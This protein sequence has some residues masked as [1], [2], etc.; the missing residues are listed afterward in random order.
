V[1][2]V[3]PRIERVPREVEVVVVEALREILGGRADLDEVGAPGPAQR[4]RWL[5]EEHV[6]VDRLIRPAGRAV[7]ARDEPYDRRIAFGECALLRAAGGRGRCNREHR[8]SEEAELPEEGTTGR[9]HERRLRVLDVLRE[10]RSAARARCSGM[11]GNTP[12][13]RH[14][15]HG[16]KKAAKAAAG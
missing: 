15:D 7:R 12:A 14:R 1:E 5:L 13:Y 2:V 6:D 3:A 11:E 10:C 16:P 8:H 4:N 9:R